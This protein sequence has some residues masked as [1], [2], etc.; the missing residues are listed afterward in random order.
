MEEKGWGAE[1]GNRPVGGVGRQRCGLKYLEESVTTALR[2]R[3]TT[4]SLRGATS[5]M[6]RIVNGHVWRASGSFEVPQRS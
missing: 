4:A 3:Q 1:R 2:G 5:S 6:G